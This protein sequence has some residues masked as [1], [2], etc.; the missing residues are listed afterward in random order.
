MHNAPDLFSTEFLLRC[1]STSRKLTADLQPSSPVP[2]PPSPAWNEVVAIA[3][4][5]GLTPLLYTRLKQND[6][7]ACVPADVWERL[8]Q[9]YIASAVR[10]MRLYRELRTVLRCLRSAGIPVIVLKG[11]FLAEAVYGDAALRPMADVDLM[12]PRAELPRAQRVLLDM[13]GVH[14]QFE[15][16]EAYVRTKRHLPQVVVRGITIEVHWTI[17]SPTGPVRVEAAGLWNRACPFSIAGVEVLAPSPEDL[18]LHLCLHACYQNRLSE[19]RGLVDIAET[20]KRFGGLLDRERFA[21]RASAWGASRYVGLTLH[22]ARSML[23]AEVPDA[24]LEQLAPGGIDQRILEAAREAVLT[25]TGYGQW[26]PFFDNVQVTSLGDKARLSWKRVFLSRDEMAAMYP[27]SRN[28]RHL[29]FYYAR[30]VGHV[31]RSFT[32]HTL[33]RAGLMMQRRGRD[34]NATLVRW[35]N[36]GKP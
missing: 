27:A 18:M 25:Q 7:Q 29:C 16:I 15:E 17:A 34:R 24:V 30:R 26:Q 6:A 23:G 21:A 14:Q 4:H 1:L 33:R 11:A 13:G 19:L 22:L 9:V 32:T 2:R 31:V 5:H 36:G 10:G 12:V 28:S 20:A 3:A 35:L 8:R